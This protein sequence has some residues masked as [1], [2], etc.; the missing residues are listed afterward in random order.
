MGNR[1]GYF[2]RQG[3]YNIKSSFLILIAFSLTL[4][5][6]AGLFF[7]S[8]SY[9]SYL[10]EDDFSEMLDFNFIFSRSTINPQKG[11]ETVESDFLQQIDSCNITF[12]DLC[13]Y[14]N[15]KSNYMRIFFNYSSI[16]TQNFPYSYSLCCSIKSLYR[17]NRWISYI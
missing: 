12:E 16:Y 8:E 10:I 4:S 1:L 14:G 6:V 17:Q 9:K 13:Y 5:M 3:I 15:F 11:F 2:T 7:Y